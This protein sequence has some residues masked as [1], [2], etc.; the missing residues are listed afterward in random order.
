MLEKTLESHLYHKEIQPVGPK[1]NQSWIFT[2]RIDTEAETPV[3]WPPDVKSP[4]IGKDPDA[5]KGGG[6]GRRGR[7][8]MKWLDRIT[9]SMDMNLSKHLDM[10][11]DK[12][13]WWA[14]VHGVSKSWTQLRNWKIAYR[15]ET[16]ENWLTHQNGQ[17]PH[18]KYC[19]QLK[20]KDVGRG[21][22]GTLEEMNATHMEIENKCLVKQR[23]ALSCRNNRVDCQAPRH[24]T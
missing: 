20:I 14:A 3:L 16:Q 22:L 24:H 7:Q 12:G 13:S 8:R 1:G 15:G 10:V 6:L 11:K 18:L 17:N 21:G 23:F 5:G 4:H 9:D 19:L 2:K